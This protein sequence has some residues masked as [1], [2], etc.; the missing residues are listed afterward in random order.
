[1]LFSQ[2]RQSS[3]PQPIRISIYQVLLNTI[4]IR[5]KM[6]RRF[7]GM[8]GQVMQ[9]SISLSKDI[10]PPS[11]PLYGLREKIPPRNTPIND[12]STE[13]TAT[14]AFNQLPTEV[15][16]QITSHLSEND[17]RVFSCT[18]KNTYTCL[19]MP[20]HRADWAS[21]KSHL[22]CMYCH[23]VRV[24]DVLCESCNREW[25]GGMWKWYR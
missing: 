25:S 10:D 19:D 18:S 1:M 3:R 13:H 21:W 5:F 8:R 12:P 11:S 4:A 16:L 6:L 2:T 14:H 24:M 15:L 17:A 7:S 20:K 9:P 23:K 22:C